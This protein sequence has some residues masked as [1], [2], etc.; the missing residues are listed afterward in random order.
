MCACF[1]FG[2][3]IIAHFTLECYLFC[4][5]K[6]VNNLWLYSYIKNQKIHNPF[7]TGWKELNSPSSVLYQWIITYFPKKD[8][9]FQKKLAFSRSICYN[10]DCLSPRTCVSGSWPPKRWC[11][12]W[13]FR[14]RVTGC[15]EV[16]IWQNVNSAARAWLLVVKFLTRCGIPTVPGS[17]ISVGLRQLLTEPPSACTLA[18]AACVLAK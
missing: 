9:S 3:L 13:K 7:S 8:N 5:F 10:F 12:F 15:K 4:D 6:S 17:P 1:L 11:F 14:F 18:P 16:Q 2:S